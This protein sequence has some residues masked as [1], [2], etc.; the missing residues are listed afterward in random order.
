MKFK[1]TRCEQSV[2][3]DVVKVVNDEPEDL[4]ENKCLLSMFILVQLIPYSDVKHRESSCNMDIPSLQA[5]S[6]ATCYQS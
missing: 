4:D 5:L 1:A 6:L 2:D 3:S